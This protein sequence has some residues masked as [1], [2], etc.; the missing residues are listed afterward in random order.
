VK[1]L[2]NKGTAKA[3]QP[4]GYGRV[5]L[6]VGAGDERF[7][8]EV[9]NGEGFVRVASTDKAAKADAMITVV[10]KAIEDA[11]LCDRGTHRL[12]RHTRQCVEACDGVVF[13]DDIE[14]AGLM[15][16]LIKVGSEAAAGDEIAIQA[17]K[18]ATTEWIV[19]GSAYGGSIRKGHGIGDSQPTVRRP[20]HA[21]HS[22]ASS[23]NTDTSN[24]RTDSG[25]GAPVAVTQSETEANLLAVFAMR[26]GFVP[27][28]RQT[29]RIK[30]GI[31]ALHK[32][33]K[34]E[35]CGEGWR[36]T[37]EERGERGGGFTAEDAEGK[38]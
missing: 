24:A 7:G 18:R 20:K 14:L 9:Y 29:E 3:G 1:D 21:T 25:P 28:D 36:L 6:T 19:A 34:I 16:E 33:G 11:I 5:R 12:N 4:I 26:P 23:E 13:R 32:A 35:R 27:G 30:R 37:A 22:Q 15:R 31:E 10:R 17:W 8:V 2:R 38:S